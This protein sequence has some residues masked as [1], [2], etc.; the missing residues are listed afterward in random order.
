VTSVADSPAAAHAT[1]SDWIRLALPGLIWGTSFYFIAVGLT[2]FPAALI[3]P[4][5]IGFGFLT[6]STVPSARRATVPRDDLVRIAVLGAVWMAFPLTMF[7]F[8]EERV[9]SSVTGMLNGGTPLFVAGIAAFLARRLPP[10]RQ[11]IGLFVGLVGVALIAVPTWGEDRSSWIGVL[12]ILAALVAYGVAL[13]IAVPLQQRH[14]SLAV[15]WRSQ[16]V[17][18]AITAP[19]GLTQVGGVHFAWGPLLAV[20]ALGMLGT[21]LAYVLM[22]NNA[23]RMGSTRAS[24]TTYLIPVVALFL[25]AAIHG[26][27]IAL[28]AVIGCAI[29]LLGAWLAGRA[30]WQVHQDVGR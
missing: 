3:A 14:G 9:S 2:A 21:A 28:L 6:L 27:R 26:E 13:N 17:A 23:G 19:I 22:A 4:M 12:M 20:A 15:M 10:R 25:G 1:T 7:A 11:L 24:V 30:R 5:R 8:A 16:A 29:A 18:L